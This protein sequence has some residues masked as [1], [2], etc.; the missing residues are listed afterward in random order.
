MEKV[1]TTCKVE[2]SFDLFSKD[3]QSKDGLTYNCRDCRNAKAKLHPSNSKEKRDLRNLKFKDA[4]RIYYAKPENQK[5]LRN[6]MLRKAYGITLED[7]NNLFEQQQGLCGICCQPQKSERNKSLAVD[8]NHETGKVRGLLCDRCN[9]GLG[10]LR[11]NKQIL[12]QAI[13]YLTRNEK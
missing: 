4:R 11:D 3:K 2:K 8:H 5:R 7:Y 10:L 9:R 1:C 12:Q 6:E 13:D